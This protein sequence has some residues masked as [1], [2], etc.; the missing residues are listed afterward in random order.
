MLPDHGH[1]ARK[2]HNNQGSLAFALYKMTAQPLPGVH[3]FKDIITRY[4]WDFAAIIPLNIGHPEDDGV[5]LKLAR[6]VANCDHV[7]ETGCCGVHAEKL[8]VFICKLGSTLQL[9]L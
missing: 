9:L 2:A 3:K 8:C 4:S 6:R 1:T 7:T 5:A